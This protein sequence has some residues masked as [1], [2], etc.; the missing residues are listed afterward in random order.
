MLWKNEVSLFGCIRHPAE[1][2]ESTKGGRL[3]KSHQF[4][5]EGEEVKVKGSPTVG[6][7]EKRADRVIAGI[8]MLRR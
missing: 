4:R 3:S 2:Y 6:K 5:D 8:A 7:E 1:Y